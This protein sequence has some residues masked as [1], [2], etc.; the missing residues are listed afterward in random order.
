MFAAAVE[1]YIVF[2]VE[3]PNRANDRISAIGVAV[4]EGQSVVHEYY[5]LINPETHFDAYNTRL[6]GIS[7]ENVADKPNFAE[8]WVC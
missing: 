4:V 5:T 1:R 3:T 6:T 7:P 8:V 2:D